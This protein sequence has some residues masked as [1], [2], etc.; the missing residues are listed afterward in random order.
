MFS[1]SAG[2]QGVDQ[3]TAASEESK[4]GGANSQIN[5][6]YDWY[7]NVTHVFIGYK[8]KQGGE[9]LINGVLDIKF[10]ES[11]MVLENSQ[12]GEILTQVDFSNKIDPSASTW[13]CSVKRIDIKL[14]KA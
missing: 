4:T 7:Q 6:Q 5:L 11:S 14:K 2:A 10:T 13:T 8:I 1:S 12:T 3:K 9:G